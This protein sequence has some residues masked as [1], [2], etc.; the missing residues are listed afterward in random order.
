MQDTDTA[1][2]SR[3]RKLPAG[4]RERHSRECATHAGKKRC[5]CAPS[6]EAVVSY[7]RGERRRKTFPTLTEAK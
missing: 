1:T 4:I 2:A 6:F 5:S 3:P 7:A